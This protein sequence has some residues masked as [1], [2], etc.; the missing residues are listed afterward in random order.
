M[1]SKTHFAQHTLDKEE[2]I[3]TEFA[4]V[5]LRYP[6]HLHQIEGHDNW[7]MS[8]SFNEKRRRGFK[9]V[10]YGAQEVVSQVQDVNDGTKNIVLDSEIPMLVDC[11]TLW[12]EPCRMIEPLIEELVVKGLASLI[13]SPLI[14]KVDFDI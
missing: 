13:L 4:F 3:H 12:C 7:G 11:S 5:L 14:S 10:V 6:S 8:S 2:F 1:I 9:G